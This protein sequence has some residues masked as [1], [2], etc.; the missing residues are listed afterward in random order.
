MNVLLKPFASKQF[1]GNRIFAVNSGDNI[2]FGFQKKL[3]TKGIKINT[4]DLGK[5]SEADKIVYCDVPYFWDFSTWLILVRNTKKN[6]LFCFESPLI[7]PFSHIKLFF[8]FFSRVYTWNDLAI[9]S[10][11][12]NKFF[13]PVLNYKKNTKKIL[14]KKKK[15]MRLISANKFAPRVF[16]LM[17]PFKKNLYLERIKV[18]DYYE[19]HGSNMFDLY[20]KGWNQPRKFNLRDKLFGFKFYK[21]YKGLIPKSL[22]SKLHILSKYKFY[23]CFENSVAPGYISEKIMDCFKSRVVPIYYGAPNIAQYIPRNTFIDY[24]DFLSPESLHHFISTMDEK[25]L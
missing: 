5:P 18:I 2:F 19:G 9:S 15:L 21:N 13:L 10:P 22:P 24:R 6:I 16:L 12:I 7:N 4:I 23:L 14:F 17:S 8:I 11:R 1:L 20:G 3:E 25:N